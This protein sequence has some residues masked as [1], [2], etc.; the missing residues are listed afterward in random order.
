MK[1]NWWMRSG[2]FYWND[3]RIISDAWLDIAA[4]PRV[5]L[6]QAETARIKTE[7]TTDKYREKML[8]LVWKNR[9][10]DDKIW[11]SGSN[12]HLLQGVMKKLRFGWDFTSQEAELF[13]E[14]LKSGVIQSRWIKSEKSTETISLGYEVWPDLTDIFEDTEEKDSRIKNILMQVAWVLDDT[15]ISPETWIEALKCCQ[16]KSFK[17]NVK[18]MDSTVI[19]EELMLRL[20]NRIVLLRF[21]WLQMETY[22]GTNN[23]NDHWIGEMNWPSCT[24]CGEEIAGAQNFTR[25][26]WAAL[27]TSCIPDY[28]KKNHVDKKH[29]EYM[30]AVHDAMF[31][32]RVAAK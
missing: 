16:D 7:E 26:A 14:L 29:A 4:H 2:G 10:F 24:S 23:S 22:R 1:T 8:G 25:A 5:L 28:L 27:H 18:V 17:P 12:T 6:K 15:E 32:Q 9:W 31:P 30:K 11:D 21:H 13:F 19:M 20:K 3:A